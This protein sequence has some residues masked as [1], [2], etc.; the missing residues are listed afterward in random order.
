MEHEYS[1]L[2]DIK[3]TVSTFNRLFTENVGPIDDHRPLYLRAY[4][5]YYGYPA[6]EADVP[7]YTI[8]RS[9]VSRCYLRGVCIQPEISKLPKNV[10]GRIV[11]S[12]V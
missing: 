1:I 11:N 10:I 2:K 6:V 4:K 5:I 12:G 7:V 9:K 3:H 8:S